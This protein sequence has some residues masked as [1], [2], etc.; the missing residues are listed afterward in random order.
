M[1]RLTVKDVRRARGSG[2]DTVPRSRHIAELD[3]A[4]TPVRLAG[5]PV[6]LAAAPAGL[7]RTVREP[8]SAKAPAN[9]VGPGP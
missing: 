3:G 6:R 9:P 8:G 5:T 4:G 2:G 7:T 1:E